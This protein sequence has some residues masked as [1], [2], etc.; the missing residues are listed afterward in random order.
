MLSHCL[1]WPA[2]KQLSFFQD[3]SDRIE[4]ES[5]TS[6]IMQA[7][8]SGAVNVCRGD[9]RTHIT[10]DL[11][12]GKPAIVLSVFHAFIN[13]LLYRFEEIQVLSR[14]IGS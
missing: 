5:Y 11:Q 14:L 2:E 13:F 4:K 1:F 7:L 8:E 3:V 10:E 9:W 6:P 12:E